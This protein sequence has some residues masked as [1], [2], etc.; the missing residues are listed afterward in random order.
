MG[1]GRGRASQESSE[2]K[3][4]NRKD[5]ELPGLSY[6]LIALIQLRDLQDQGRSNKF[7]PVLEES[8]QLKEDHLEAGDQQ[9]GVQVTAQTV[10]EADGGPWVLP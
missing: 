8:D 2:L 4:H 5:L 3:C 9:R 7:R 1:V 6:H 10:P